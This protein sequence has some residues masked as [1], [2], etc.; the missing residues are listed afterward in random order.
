MTCAWLT[1][2]AA[3][4]HLLLVGCA[5]S[6]QTHYY[7]L[8]DRAQGDR[9]SPAKVEYAVAVGPVF[10]PDVVD[11]PHFVVH[12]PGNEVR[13]VEQAR[14][15]EPLR[16][17]IARAVAA[18]LA[19][20]LDTGRVSSR[21]QSGMGEADYRVLMDVQRFD[22]MPGEA[23]VLEVMWTVRREKNGELRTGNA[24]IREPIPGSSYQELVA[25]HARALD[26]VSGKIAEA[27]RVLRQADLAVAPASIR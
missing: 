21:A 14:W 22:S 11:R 7:T 23:A 6:P 2:A 3:L 27:I 13:I 8:V 1:R 12:L 25:A 24:R 15:A 17:G 9:V 20:S 16:D 18:N 5:G 4:L 10:V 26:T 19:H